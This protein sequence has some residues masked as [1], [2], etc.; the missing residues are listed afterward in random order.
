[1]MVDWSL[2]HRWRRSALRG[3][4]LVRIWVHRVLDTV[5]R[6]PTVWLVL[7]V[8][9]TGLMGVIRVAYGIRLSRVCVTRILLG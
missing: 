7:P 9:E 6:I 3:D 8:C 5:D 1:M 2:G 4:C